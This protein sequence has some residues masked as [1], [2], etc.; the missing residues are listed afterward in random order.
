MAPAASVVP[1]LA[2]AQS[3]VTYCVED[4]GAVLATVT[5]LIVVVGDGGSRSRGDRE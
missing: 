5:A 4:R 1:K 2:E 3:L